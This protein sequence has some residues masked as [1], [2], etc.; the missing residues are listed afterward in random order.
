MNIEGQIRDEKLQFDINRE[1]ANISAL[2]LG[3][4][5]K[6]EYLTGEEIL[7]SN[8]QQVIEQAKFTYS[9]LEKAFEKQTKTIKDQGEKHVSALKSLES[10]DKQITI[11]KRLYIKRKAKS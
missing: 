2:S 6:Y 5:D 10:S 4:I 1:T 9:P 8:Q 11:D 7:P 3:K